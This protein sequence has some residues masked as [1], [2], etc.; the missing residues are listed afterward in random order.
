MRW[1]V[2][3]WRGGELRLLLLA[4]VIAVT[5]VSGITGFADRLQRGIVQQSSQFVA[6]DRVLLSPRPVP[7]DWLQ[8]AEQIGLRSAVVASFQTMA[9]SD[10]GMQ[11]ASVKAVSDAYPLKGTLQNSVEPFGEGQP[12]SDGPARGE[13]WIDSRLFPLLDIDPGAGLGL[14]EAELRVS[15]ALISEPDRGSSYYGVGPRVLMHFDDL[16]AT[17]VIQPGSLVEYRYQFAGSE[18]QLE[19]YGQWLQSRLQPSHRWQDLADSQ[20]QIARSLERAERFLLLA[21]SFGVA[22]AGVAVALAARRYSERHY[23]VVGV[24]KALGAQNRAIMRRYV[25]NL[26][27]L[28]LVAVVIGSGLGWLLQQSLLTLIGDLLGFVAPASGWRPVLTGAVTAMVC[29]LAFALPPVL[30]L[31][32]VSPLRVLRRDVPVEGLGAGAS[33]VI[34][35][36]GLGLL[37]WW[38][39]SDALLALSVLAGVLLMLLVAALLVWRV[40]RGGRGLG[41]QA[42]GSVRL[43]L[44]AL[45]RRARANAFQVV[46]FALAL[47]VLLSLSVVRGSLMEEWRLQLPENTPNHFLINIQPYQIERVEALL[48]DSGVETAGLYPMVRGRLTHI[49]GEPIASL[50]YLKTEGSSVNREANLSWAEALPED[51]RLLAGQWWQQASGAGVARVSVEQRFAE[52]VRL[53]IG[54]TL[55]YD[56][57]G[58]PL[59]AQVQSIREL[60]WDSMRPNFFLLF[61]PGVLDSYPATYITSFYLPREQKVLLNT[62]I[63]EFPTVTLIEMDA[64]IDQLRTIVQQISSA[65]ELVLVLIVVCALLVTVANVQSSLDSRLQEN[66]ILRALGAPTSLI[67]RSLLLEFAMMGLLAG[68]FAAAGSELSLYLLQTQVLNMDFSGHRWLWLVGPLLG[69]VLIS[70]VGWRS[71]RVVVEAPP[72]RVLNA[73]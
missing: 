18:A 60:D 73:L 28:G 5:I 34:G 43:A 3:E 40:I 10:E 21:G 56:I 65:I 59:T 72:L 66:A 23:D 41:M 54:S 27:L 45:N 32:G 17:R 44:A 4:L 35:L 8:Q 53:E 71:C 70:L 19:Q 47:M 57:G 15:R 13:A 25:G 42:V 11:L 33:I 46:S 67:R 12:V 14:G 50:D 58:M 55:R 30:L 48:G 37:M 52:R 38:Y 29:L 68:L 9:F 51:N 2:R 1:L 61:E 26:L 39:T 36:A 24:M 22:L 62:L 6:A 16:A 69:V 63:R 20:P 7:E 31:R 49:D 64:V